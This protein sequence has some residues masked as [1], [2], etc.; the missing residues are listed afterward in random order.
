[1]SVDHPR[2]IRSYARRE[3]TF[4]EGAKALWERRWPERGI[5]ETAWPTLGLSGKPTV[6]DIGFGDGEALLSAADADPE[7]HYVGVEVYK[8]GIMKVLRALAERD[9]PNVKLIEGDAQLVLA[10]LPDASL[11]EVRVFFP[12]PWPKARHH[13]RRLVRAPF[14]N[15][16]VRTL[17]P[18]GLFHMA[19]DWAPYAE[20]VRLTM[21]SLKGLEAVGEER[22]TRVSSKFERR[23]QRLGNEPTDLRF[24]KA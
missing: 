18:G 16:V 23:G 14:L 17:K 24:R 6:L 12:D 22:G 11:D 20:E 9:I 4:T 1:V 19:T 8:N 7:R 5:C 15:E 2:R 10:V 3:R 21:E 13:K